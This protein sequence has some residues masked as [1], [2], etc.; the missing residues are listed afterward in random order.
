MAGSLVIQVT[1]ADES[2]ISV[3]E[4]F[5]ITG[6]VLS[7]PHPVISPPAKIMNVTKID[8]KMLFRI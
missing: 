4:I 8:E 7:C 2:V 1:V 3:I 6:P 5:D